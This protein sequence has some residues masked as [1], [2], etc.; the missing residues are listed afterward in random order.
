MHAAIEGRFNFVDFYGRR[1][2]RIFPALI[3]VLAFCMIY[4]WVMLLPHDYAEL[5]E[6]TAGG[7][8]FVSNFVLLAQS[9]YFSAAAD[10]KPLLHLWSLGI[11]EQYYICWPLIL[12]I[13]CRR[14]WNML[15]VIV[16]LAS[17]SFALNV[18][19]VRADAA[20]TF[21]LPQTR[22]WELLLGAALA[23]LDQRGPQRESPAWSAN[24]RSAIGMLCIAA[25]ILAITETFQFP[26]WWALL[27]TLG[28][29]LV[30]SSGSRAWLN[31]RIL[32]NGAL[33]WFG[34]IS[35]P[36][37]I[38][39]WPLLSLASLHHGQFPSRN[40]RLLIVAASI[41]LAWL[42]YRCVEKPIRFKANGGR[43]S[44]V[45]LLCMA[46][47]G[48]L[49]FAIYWKAGFP[50]R[51]PR[52]VQ[53]IDALAHDN[54][55]ESA[56]RERSCFLE[57]D[58]GPPAFSRCDPA[59]L[60]SRKPV[61][62]LWGDSLAAQLYPGYEAA[63]G[64]QFTI[65]QRTSSACAP[66]FGDAYND[67]LVNC[68]AVNASIMKLIEQEKPARVVLSARWSVH[69][70]PKIGTTIERLREAGVRDID[71]IGPV[72]RWMGGL[73]R[74]L[75]LFMEASKVPSIPERMTFGLEPGYEAIEPSL[76]EVA[77]KYRINYI[78]PLSIL[79]DDRG[80]LTR[81][82]NTP[83]TVTSFDYDHLSSAGSIFAVSRFPGASAQI[84]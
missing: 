50:Q 26:G 49:G 60:P 17:V 10:A 25:G 74:Q 43:K 30:I 57:L 5:G 14:G 68:N 81:T 69:D 64:R 24:A 3:I 16:A 34:L 19:Q 44:L 75:I 70:W 67:R 22:I 56:W 33:V 7:A 45:L 53:Q 59:Q 62:L 77:E 54:D 15:I 21:Y 11:E 32:S 71:L 40:I 31:R 79:C 13:G 27:P 42:T 82:G 38:W 36:L 1:I 72:P 55:H 84:Q 46:I 4:G 6:N 73:P 39:H 52:L 12:W 76:Q 80:C 58:Q 37:Y 35:Y 61:I 47:V 28:T 63:F 83:D 29:A 65:V 20:A 78:S 2:R 66:I 18:A 48:S 51:F 41:M 8:G 23:A 9:G